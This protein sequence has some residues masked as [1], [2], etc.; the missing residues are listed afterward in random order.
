MCV[1]RADDRDIFSIGSI[2]GL[3]LGFPAFD[4]DE[5][6]GRTWLPGSPE[7]GVLEF[8]WLCSIICL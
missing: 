4:S 6:R 8:V 3:L 2:S 7:K 5:D 1:S